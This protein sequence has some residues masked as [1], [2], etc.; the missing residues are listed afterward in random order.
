MRFIPHA[1]HSSR[2][3]PRCGAGVPSQGGADDRF[4][5]GEMRAPAEKLGCEAGIGDERRWVAGPPRSIAS[6]VSPYGLTGSC[7]V[8]SRIGAPLPMPY[9]AQVEEKTI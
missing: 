5:V 4:E 7:G 1:G 8:V 6:L 3:L 9:V 2:R